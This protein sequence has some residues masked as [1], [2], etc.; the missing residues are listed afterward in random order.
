MR[1][2]ADGGNAVITVGDRT[3]GGS[4]AADIRRAGAENGC[5][6]VLST[7]GAKLHNGAAVGGTGN[8]VC[9]GGNK[10]LMVCDKKG[11]RFNKLGLNRR[12]FYYDNRLPREYGGT[13]RNTPDVAFEFKVSQIA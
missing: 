10:A 7:A 4:H 9:L 5:V 3:G 12:A 1:H 2:C 6:R 13:L 11:Y 8:A